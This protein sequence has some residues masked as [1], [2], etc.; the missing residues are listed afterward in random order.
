MISFRYCGQG[1]RDSPL[2]VCTGCDNHNSSTRKRK[3]QAKT[4]KIAN[5][6][7]KNLSQIQTRGK[8]G[9]KKWD[10]QRE[11][12]AN[13]TRGPIVYS[14]SEDNTCDLSRAF[15]TEIAVSLVSVLKT[16]I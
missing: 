14:W 9:L 12:R 15:F 8:F 10:R 2:G 7:G 6:S 11:I 4:A 13:F 1:A 3:I 5:H 16:V